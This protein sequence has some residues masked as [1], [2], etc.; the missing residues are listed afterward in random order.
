MSQS[1]KVGLPPGT[2]IYIGEKDQKVKI[3]HISYN[4]T[5]YNEREVEDFKF[6]L[7][8]D[9][10]HWFNIEGLNN[11]EIIKMVGLKFDID[12]LV[13]EDVV[14]TKQRPKIDDMEDYLHVIMKF[15]LFDTSKAEIINEH[16]SF[17]LGNNYLITFQEFL[18]DNF[19]LMNI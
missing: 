1:V 15:I 14:N 12:P 16:Y 2:P 17:I 7:K 8:D 4:P 18:G 13:L 6:D 5:T 19:V 11:I 9:L 3:T 10:I